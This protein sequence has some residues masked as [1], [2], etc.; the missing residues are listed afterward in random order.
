MDHS[1]HGEN[2]CKTSQMDTFACYIY[3]I[4]IIY[5][6]IIVTLQLLLHYFLELKGP[7]AKS[8]VF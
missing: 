6:Y 1:L 3:T 8:N 4:I 7:I 2:A 5:R